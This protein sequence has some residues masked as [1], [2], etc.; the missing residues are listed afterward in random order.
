MKLI[1]TAFLMVVLMVLVLMGL[2]NRTLVDF[3][4]PPLMSNA[5]QQPAALMYFAFFAAG[6]L[7]GTVFAFGGRKPA[8]SKADK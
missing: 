7:T 6:V 4:L 3:S 2:Y 1:K 8:Q 5:V